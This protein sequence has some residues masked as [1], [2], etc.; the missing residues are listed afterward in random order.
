MDKK[1]RQRLLLEKLRAAGS[2]LSA[3]DLAQQLD[4]TRRTIE[5]DLVELR[6][7]GIAVTGDRG[8]AG[9]ARIEV[10]ASTPGESNE[11][12]ATGGTLPHSRSNTVERSDFIGR[13]NVLSAITDAVRAGFDGA[14]STFVISGEDGIGKTRMLAESVDVGVSEGA[15][16]IAAW[17][18]H[19]LS[20]VGAWLR[21]MANDLVHVPESPGANSKHRYVAELRTLLDDEGTISVDAWTNA[22]KLAVNEITETQAILMIIDDGDLVSSELPSISDMFDGTAACGLVK[23]VSA[24]RTIRIPGPLLGGNDTRN[25]T[26][27]PHQFELLGFSVDEVQHFLSTEQDHLPDLDTTEIVHRLTHGNP[28][29]VKSL[30]TCSS[31][32]ISAL[33]GNLGAVEIPLPVATVVGTR[34]RHLSLD[35]RK[36]LDCLAVFN[37]TITKHEITAIGRALGEI[38][39]ESELAR[40]I[41]SDLLVHSSGESGAV[42]FRNNIVRTTLVSVQSH[43]QRTAFHALAVGVLRELQVLNP[44]YALDLCASHAVLAVELIGVEEAAQN[45]LEA[46]ESALER[47][48]WESARQHFQAA[49]GVST[50]PNQTIV[51]AH[52]LEGLGVALLNIND[53][54]ENERAVE[55]LEMAF[56]RYIE[57][58][59]SEKALRIASLP[60][61]AVPGRN[62]ASNLIKRGL[63]LCTDDPAASSRLFARL[64]AFNAIAEGDIYAA[65]QSASEAVAQAERSGNFRLI[66]LAYA[67]DAQVASHAFRFKQ[68]ISSAEKAL[69][70][71]GDG[72]EPVAAFVSNQAAAH[73]NL[74]AGNVNEAIQR[75]EAALAVAEVLQ[76]QH[77]RLGVMWL[78]I[79]LHMDSADLRGA[80]RISDQALGIY[81]NSPIHLGLRAWL[82]FELGNN[83]AGRTFLEQQLGVEAEPDAPY[84][85]APVGMRTLMLSAIAGITNDPHILKLAN[86]SSASTTRR[87]FGAPFQRM[88]AFQVSAGLA[89][90]Q[91]DRFTAAQLLTEYELLSSEFDVPGIFWHPAAQVYNLVGAIDRARALYEQACEFITASEQ[92][93][94][95]VHFCYD[96]GQFL[97]ERSDQASLSRASELV[98]LGI[99]RAVTLGLIPHISRLRLIKHR[100]AA[101]VVSDGLGIES[102]SD[103][104]HEVLELIAVGLSNTEIAKRL[105]LS[106][107]TVHRHVSAILNKLGVRGRTQAA[108]LEQTHSHG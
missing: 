59:E 106:E 22:V 43:A 64:S 21:N 35:S 61:A 46:G 100:I 78:L 63:S 75:A 79:R 69:T 67:H 54:F 20:D 4:V 11:A 24:R 97:L 19:E 48:K 27:E 3:Q 52:L 28:L 95:F 92:W 32:E 18:G 9:G 98:D 38:E 6:E 34:L 90:L 82:E 26:T 53:P 71:H 101:T 77:R 15:A 104:E 37:D 42:H 40:L 99:E 80:A 31:D 50:N 47:A 14:S 84:G 93:R 8:R 33:E 60:F 86:K 66:S 56:D 85:L 108:L 7:L 105:F 102:L 74:F 68:A 16:V 10:A 23:V 12:L 25:K 2:P 57:A 87:G 91:G 29:F 89:M 17:H 81:P 96:Y 65:E 5:R 76:D 72:I 107:H 49:L 1:T 45:C 73:A 44:G 103:R 94:F 36:L 58:E 62:A 83:D 39:V 13:H 51:R 41:Y 55:I 70:D 88:D 30:A